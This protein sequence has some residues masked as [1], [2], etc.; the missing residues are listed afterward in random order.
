MVYLKKIPLIAGVAVFLGVWAFFA[1]TSFPSQLCEY[2]AAE[3]AKKGSK[4]AGLW[5]KLNSD[6]MAV[7]ACLKSLYW[8]RVGGFRRITA[9]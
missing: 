4:N 8:C 6:A 7:D 5:P 9:R 2:K 3:Y 1:F